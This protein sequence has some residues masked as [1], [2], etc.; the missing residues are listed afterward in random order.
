MVALETGL[1]THDDVGVGRALAAAE[2]ALAVAGVE[3]RL[4]RLR[5]DLRNDLGKMMMA[6]GLLELELEGDQVER[7]RQVVAAAA[8]ASKKVDA[9]TLRPEPPESPAAA[10]EPDSRADG[11]RVLV[12]DDDPIAGATLAD[13]LRSAGA[14]VVLVACLEVAFAELAGAPFEAAL[15]DL[16]LGTESGADL[17]PA[18]R[19]SGV[20]AVAY[21]GDSERA[22]QDWDAVVPKGAHASAIISAL[23][24]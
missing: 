21:T 23:T 16:S 10:P 14:E 15:V 22:F 6:A 7:A 1:D 12:V 9:I 8:E 19:K 24:A 3:E 5:H 20:R 17:L 13:M 2:H 18:L 11:L 4:R